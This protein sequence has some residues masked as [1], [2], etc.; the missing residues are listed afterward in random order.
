MPSVAL[1][2]SCLYALFEPND[3][4]HAVAKQFLSKFQ[5]ELVSNLAVLTEVVY[6]LNYSVRTQYAFIQFAA[7]SITIDDEA[8]GDLPRIAE[9]MQKYADL[10]ADFADAALLAM[11]ERLDIGEIATFDSDFD[12]YRLANGKPLLN[13]TKES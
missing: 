2:S 13:V 7:R 8:A 12:V 6:L 10:P 9:I 3:Q 4:G 11:C 5:G 1:D